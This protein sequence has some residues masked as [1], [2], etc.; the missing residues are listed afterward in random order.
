MKNITQYTRMWSIRR[1][2]HPA[3]M[4]NWNQPII[5]LDLNW[6]LIDRIFCDLTSRVKLLKSA[7]SYFWRT[8]HTCTVYQEFIL[9]QIR[10]FATEV[11]ARQVI[12][13]F[14]ETTNI[15]M[16]KLH[17]CWSQTRLWISRAMTVPILQQNRCIDNAIFINSGSWILTHG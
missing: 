4:E 9:Q 13:L 1:G 3:K 14:F 10:N 8:K 11:P 16:I 7:L 5:G 15:E 12:I 2:R 6:E 17:S